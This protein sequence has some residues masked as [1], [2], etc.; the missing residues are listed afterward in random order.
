[1]KYKHI[2]MFLLIIASGLFWGW[3][4]KSL[5]TSGTPFTWSYI[6]QYVLI[7]IACYLAA[8]LI[9]AL[10]LRLFT[11]DLHVEFVYLWS[12]IGTALIGSFLFEV[13][14]LNQSINSD[15]WYISVHQKELYERHIYF[16]IEFFIFDAVLFSIFSLVLILSGKFIWG[17]FERRG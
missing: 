1:M 11:K 6:L 13:Y 12:V 10:C 16:S 4:L 7:Y 14:N 8:Y 5:K 17:L 3:Q 9:V 15:W 2:I